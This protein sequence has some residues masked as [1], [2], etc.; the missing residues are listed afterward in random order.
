[1]SCSC[2]ASATSRATP[3]PVPWQDVQ[4]TCAVEVQLGVAFAP[5]LKLPW[6]YVD[7]QVALVPLAHDPPPSLDSN[8]RSRRLP[9]S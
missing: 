5:P 4:V 1:M 3:E 8:S 6:Q 7:A 9:R 2:R